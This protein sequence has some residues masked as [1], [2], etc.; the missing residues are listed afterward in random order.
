LP[1]KPHP[2][3]LVAMCA[4]HRRVLAA[5]A[6]LS[7]CGL[8]PTASVRDEA[9]PRTTPAGQGAVVA[10]ISAV[11]GA[12]IAPPQGSGT[13]ADLTV[14]TLLAIPAAAAPHAIWSLMRYP[15]APRTH[16]STAD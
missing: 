11:D 2:P 7:R 10:D 6:F 15:G 8:K 1:L 4:V 14:R 13:V 5:L 12:A 9:A 16:A 3:A